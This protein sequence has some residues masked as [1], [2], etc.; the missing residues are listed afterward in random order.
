[1]KR[2]LAVVLLAFCA[3]AWA[4]APC[5]KPGEIKPEALLGT[6]QAELPG[7]WDAATLKLVKHPEYAGSFRG[8]LERGNRT[9]QVAGEY[10]EDEG[11]FALEESADGTHIAAAWAG[12]LVEGSC[13]REIRGTWTRDGEAQGAPFVIRKR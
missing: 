5:P 13:G 1:M 7:Q 9:W 3:T 12:E 2:A 6:W 11:T 10:D 8:T 4:Q